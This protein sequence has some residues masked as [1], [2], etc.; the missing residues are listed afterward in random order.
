MK[1]LYHGHRYVL[2]NVDGHGTQILQF[3]QRTPHHEP[4][5]GVLNQEVLRA[6]IER[7]QHLD[8]ELPHPAN[9]QI[10]HHL[11]MALVLHEA[12]AMVRDVEK[13]DLKPE[14]VELDSGGHFNLSID[15][16]RAF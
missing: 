4:K 3:V 6:L 12:R 10:L 13:G 16:P 5:E 9:A 7:V 15:D 14:L 11:R 8:G 1:V 2:E